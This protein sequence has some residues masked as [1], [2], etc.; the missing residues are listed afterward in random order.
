MVILKDLKSTRYSGFIAQ[1]AGVRG[2]TGRAA[3]VPNRAAPPASEH[4]VDAGHG[5]VLRACL[6]VTIALVD[7]T[8]VFGLPCTMLFCHH[9]HSLPIAMFDFPVL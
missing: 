1:E 9:H 6:E 8:E 5:R 7:L 3:T 2:A 4:A